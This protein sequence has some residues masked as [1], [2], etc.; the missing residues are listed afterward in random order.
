[1]VDSGND[2]II[3]V[4]HKKKSLTKLVKQVVSQHPLS[5]RSVTVEH[6]RGRKEV[7]I[8]Q[9]YDPGQVLYQDWPSVKRVI[10]IR[11]KRTH[12]GK[13]SDQVHYYISSINHDDAEAYQRIIRNHWTIENGLHWV[14]DVIMKEDKTIF[15]NYKAYSLNTLFRNT[16]FTFIKLNGYS[17]I[18]H[19]LEILRANPKL[20]INIFR[21]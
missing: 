7:R 10:C 15:H 2:Y 14:K 17:S 16:I 1:M 5:G 21:I 6:Q 12:K 11:R 18:K 20:I 4:K 19:G 8:L 3:Q 9:V 13:E